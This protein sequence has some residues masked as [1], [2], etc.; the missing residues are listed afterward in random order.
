[1]A[2]S[3]NNYQKIIMIT[4]LVT[5]IIYINNC[6]KWCNN[7]GHF[8]QKGMYAYRFHNHYCTYKQHFADLSNTELYNQ[9]LNSARTGQNT[10]PAPL[11]GAPPPQTG[12]PV[13]QKAFLH[14]TLVK[15]WKPFVSCIDIK[16]TFYMKMH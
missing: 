16:Y 1:L 10:I 5:Y 7:S 6:R 4:G 3:G 8:Y 11:V 9:W 15:I 12:I 13:P 2:F 14:L